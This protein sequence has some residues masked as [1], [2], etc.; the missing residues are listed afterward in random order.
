MGKAQT[1]DFKIDNKNRK[2]KKQKKAEKSRKNETSKQK[3]QKKK[4]KHIYFQLYRPR[5]QAGT[6]TCKATVSPVA[7]TITTVHHTNY[8]ALH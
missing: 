6:V 2:N 3:K 7:T 5:T 4:Q 1:A 8:I